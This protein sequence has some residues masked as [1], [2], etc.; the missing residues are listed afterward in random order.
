MVVDAASPQAARELI[1]W[2]RGATANSGVTFLPSLGP[3]RRH[4]STLMWEINRLGIEGL[5]LAWQD[6]ALVVT[7]QG[8]SG[9]YPIARHVLDIHAN[10]PSR[11]VNVDKDTVVAAA[12]WAVQYS[13]VTLMP[14]WVRSAAQRPGPSLE[15]L[16]S[17]PLEGREPALRAD[18]RDRVAAEATQAGLGTR[19]P[20]SGAATEAAM[21]ALGR[22]VDMPDAKSPRS[23]NGATGSG[24]A[25]QQPAP[26]GTVAAAGAAA[27]KTSAEAAGAGVGRNKTGTAKSGA[28]GVGV[29]AGASIPAGT[30]AVG[31][32]TAQGPPTTSTPLSYAQAAQSVAAK[33]VAAQSVTARDSDGASD[34]IMYSSDGED[35][36]GENIPGDFSVVGKRR[37]KGTRTSLSAMAAAAVKKGMSVKG[38]KLQYPVIAGGVQKPPP[39]P[40]AARS[41]HKP[42]Q[43]GGGPIM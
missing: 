20:A 8:R 21:P 26:R 31:K 25:G 35:S 13:P 42:P 41:S 34:V 30:A 18:R 16:P 7:Y 19:P 4:D 38:A 32:V 1:S 40:A 43:D 33:S 12:E 23:S 36:D 3:F 22:D 9:R 27:A 17:P 39:L 14:A 11:P 2:G 24:A 37:S 28:G 6:S 10:K 29:S 5:T 15:R